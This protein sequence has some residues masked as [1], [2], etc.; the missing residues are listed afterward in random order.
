MTARS[1][2]ALVLVTIAAM[3]AAQEPIQSGFGKGAYVPGPGLSDP[4]VIREVR[5]N[6]TSAGLKARIQGQVTL[7]AI[8]L[9]NGTVGDIR[10]T[11][12]LDTQF[13]LD[14]E[15]VI[16]AKKWL[17]RPG[18]KD[19]KPVD[20]LV[21][22]ILEFRHTRAPVVMK[23]VKPVYPADVQPRVR[24]VVELEAVVGPDGKVTDVKVIKS[25][26]SRFDAEAVAAARQF[27]F[28]P[29][30]SEGKPAP[31]RVTLVLAFSPDGAPH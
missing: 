2:L 8:V 3:P 17:F 9:I 23:D 22:I 31:M 16:A 5:P 27:L 20:V 21:T 12:S 15:A 1:A 19:G 13:G 7:E 24:A 4:V 25:P 14:D 26:D 18:Y 29:G 10:V 6:Y 30:Y 28:R 11:K